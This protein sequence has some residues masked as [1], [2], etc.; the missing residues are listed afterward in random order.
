MG[1]NYV[2]QCSAFSLLNLEVFQKGVLDPQDP[3]PSG[4]AS[5]I[6]SGHFLMY[7]IFDILLHI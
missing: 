3:L 2:L 6:C 7:T 5:G 4:S 1:N